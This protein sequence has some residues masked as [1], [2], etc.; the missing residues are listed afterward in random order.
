MWCDRDWVVKRSA[1]LERNSSIRRRTALYVNYLFR[2]SRLYNAFS[3]ASTI[4]DFCVVEM[5]AFVNADISDAV[6][7]VISLKDLRFV[8]VDLWVV[9]NEQRR[10]WELL[11]V[12]ATWINF[13]QPVLPEVEIN[14]S[15]GEVSKIFFHLDPDCYFNL[16]DK[17]KYV[18][19][20]PQ[21]IESTSLLF[22]NQQ[23][24]KLYP[25]YY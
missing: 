17:Y 7:D 8:P 10:D 22:H 12:L 21:F 4:Y 16:C 23:G 19:E 13:T 2:Y 18:S 3:G 24:R 14:K 1:L 15:Q 5:S 9:R 11:Q 25:Y 20:A 6:Y